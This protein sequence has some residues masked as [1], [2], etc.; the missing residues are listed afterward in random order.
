MGKIRQGGKMRIAGFDCGYHTAMAIY[1]TN[2]K[3][4]DTLKCWHYS[5]KEEA[6][7]GEAVLCY[8][9][10]TDIVVIEKPIII[11][12]AFKEAYYTYALAYHIYWSVLN[13]E[14]KSVFQDKEK[15]KPFL[16]EARGLLNKCKNYNTKFKRH[17]VDALGHA[18]AFW[19]ECKHGT[20]TYKI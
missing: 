9:C 4:I 12:S 15:R 20:N 13:R 14:F 5:Q 16:P 11:A 3:E 1:D 6:N 18:I 7:I 8:I 19:E 10:R 2:T 17:F